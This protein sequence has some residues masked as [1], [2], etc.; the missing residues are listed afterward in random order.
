MGLNPTEYVEFYTP[1]AGEER[2]CG[3]RAHAGRPVDSGMDTPPSGA[4]SRSCAARPL[5][6]WTRPA[7]P[8][9]CTRLWMRGPCNGGPTK[10]LKAC[11][12]TCLAASRYLWR[13]VRPRM[14]TCGSA[15]AAV[16]RSQPRCGDCRNG[17]RCMCGS[18]PR[19][20][21]AVP[22][23]S[24]GGSAGA[25]GRCGGGSGGPACR[26]TPPQTPAPPE[27]RKGRSR[28]AGT[29]SPEL[30]G[31]LEAPPR[32]AHVAIS[33]AWGNARATRG[34]RPAGSAA[35]RRTVPRPT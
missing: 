12:A 20:Q 24:E 19:Q 11:G 1:R 7:Q 17:G 29:A 14:A 22:W 16:R 30:S 18:R 33:R 4:G 26:P 5:S 25:P 28:R 8:Y 2:Q 3:G 13:A 23:T 32:P 34:A 6:R 31:R 15:G 9:H 35:R 27:A 10:R 21:N